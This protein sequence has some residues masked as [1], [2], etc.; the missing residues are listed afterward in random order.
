MTLRIGEVNAM[1]KGKEPVVMTVCLQPDTAARLKEYEAIIGVSKTFVI[2][3]AVE[4]Y[5][6]RVTSKNEAQDRLVSPTLDACGPRSVKFTIRFP[7]CSA[8][9]DF[10]SAINM[11]MVY[12]DAIIQRY[13]LDAFTQKVLSYHFFGPESTRVVFSMDEK[14]L[15]GDRHKTWSNGLCFQMNYSAARL[16]AICDGLQILF[17]EVRLELQ[18]A[19]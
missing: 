17:P 3:H 14:D 11:T 9:Y 8:T 1:I 13:G 6:D 5:L 18:Y 19:D 2:E 16:M 12:I 7:V 15:F 4:E 10:R